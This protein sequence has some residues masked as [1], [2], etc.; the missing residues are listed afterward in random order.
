M[1][2]DVGFCVSRVKKCCYTKTMYVSLD[3][4]LTRFLFMN[5]VIRD[6]EA[7]SCQAIFISCNLRSFG[8]YV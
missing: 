7:L 2:K 4:I 6:D 1:N 3:H 8:P 5:C